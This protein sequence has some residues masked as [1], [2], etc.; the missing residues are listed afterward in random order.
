MLGEC[1]RTVSFLQNHY[2]Y[3]PL[4][5][6]C[7]RYLVHFK[8]QFPAA[9]K[10][11]VHT[12]EMSEPICQFFFFLSFAT[13]ALTIEY[14]FSSTPS[15]HN[16]Q[17]LIALQSKNPLRLWRVSHVLS[18]HMFRISGS[19]LRRKHSHGCRASA[20]LYQPPL[21]PLY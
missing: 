20:T 3:S 6:E 1:C 10:H 19:S 18:V 9:A 21:I 5:V 2:I 17:W 12:T 13:N 15:P 4:M 11:S 8:E 16:R 14:S 7:G